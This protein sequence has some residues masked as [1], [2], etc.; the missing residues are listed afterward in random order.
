MTPTARTGDETP[1][2]GLGEMI[3]AARTGDETPLVGQDELTPTA[4]TGEETPAYG[5]G[6]AREVDGGFAE[7]GSWLFQELTPRTPTESPDASPHPAGDEIPA[8]KAQPAPPRQMGREARSHATRAWGE[9]NH[10]D[11]SMQRAREQFRSTWDLCSRSQEAD[12]QGFKLVSRMGATIMELVAYPL[13]RVDLKLLNTLHE[14]GLVLEVRK[15]WEKTPC[16]FGAWGAAFMRRHGSSDASMRSP[17]AIAELS[18]V[19]HVGEVDIRNVEV[20]HARQHRNVSYRQQT[21]RAAASQMS[22]NRLIAWERVRVGRWSWLKQR[23][24]RKVPGVGASTSSGAVSGQ[25]AETSHAHRRGPKPKKEKCVQGSWE[26]RAWVGNH[27]P[28]NLSLIH[29]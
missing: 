7:Y 25:A 4:R 10:V 12:I 13:R 15:T 8:D 18:T 3:P 26:Y 20:D 22:A 14:P 24:E 17:D 27:A 19:E 5:T 23:G 28:R 29:I 2:A 6:H 11:A 1:L 16:L 9:G 21:H